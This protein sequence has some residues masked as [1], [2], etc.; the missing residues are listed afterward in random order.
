MRSGCKQL[1]SVT[2]F[3]VYRGLQVGAGKKS[4]AFK[5]VF[6]PDDHELTGPEVDKLVDKLLRKLTFTLGAE[7]R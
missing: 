1:A 5:L 6:T 3:D 7:L 2:L 4:M